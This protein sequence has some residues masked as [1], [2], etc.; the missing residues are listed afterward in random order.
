MFDNILHHN[1]GEATVVSRLHNMHQ[2][3]ELENL[4]WVF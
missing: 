1:D 3:S 4:D 2:A